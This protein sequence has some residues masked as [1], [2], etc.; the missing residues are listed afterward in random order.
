MW[1]R[2]SKRGS[3]VAKRYRKAA[4]KKEQEVQIYVTNSYKVIGQKRAKQKN[5]GTSK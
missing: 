3:R 2:H 5:I 1:Q 4:E